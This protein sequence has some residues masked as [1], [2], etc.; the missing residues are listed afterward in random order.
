MKLTIGRL[1]E[2]PNTP[3]NQPHWN[4]AT[5][6]PYAAPMDSTFITAALSGTRIERNTTMR[7]RKLSAIT[8]PMNHGSRDAIRSEMSMN[9]AVAPPT[10]TLTSEPGGRRRD[11]VAAQPRHEITGRLRLR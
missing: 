1:S 3:R 10:D 8:A 5:I 2:T 9:D 11:D 4:T 6:T 7:S